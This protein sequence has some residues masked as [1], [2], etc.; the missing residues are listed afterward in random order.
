[1]VQST[2][3]RD[4]HQ[5]TALTAEQAY[6]LLRVW[7]G[8]TDKEAQNRALIAVLLLSS[9]AVALRWV[10]RCRFRE[11]CAAHPAG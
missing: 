9:E 10:D 2:S 1:M 5:K 4:E 3:N 7:D 6:K 11:R 8:T